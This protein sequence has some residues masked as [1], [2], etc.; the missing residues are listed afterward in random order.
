VNKECESKI[1]KRFIRET[2]RIN[3][4]RWTNKPQRWFCAITG[5]KLIIGKFNNNRRYCSI[6][7][8]YVSIC[9]KFNF[10][11]VRRLRL[12]FGHKTSLKAT[13]NTLQGIVCNPQSM[14]KRTRVARFFL[15]QHTKMET[16]YQI[17]IKY[18]KRPQILTKWPYNRPNGHKIY[19]PLPKFTQIR[20][21][22]LKINHLATL[23]RTRLSSNG[24]LL[25]TVCSHSWKISLLIR[26]QIPVFS[27]PTA[28][29]NYKTKTSIET[30]R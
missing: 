25:Q 18:T 4:Q 11:I 2:T 5:G 29:I 17:T 3:R 10:L 13:L 20:I 26:G 27:L 8:F 21:F 16:I 30:D 1:R 7:W 14:C 9:C 6:V 23:R 19:Q 12:V 24:L 22:V 28:S 15:V